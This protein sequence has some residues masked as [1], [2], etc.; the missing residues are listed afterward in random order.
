MGVLQPRR[1]SGAAVLPTTS[2]GGRPCGSSPRG[3]LPAARE[4]YGENSAM[5]DSSVLTKTPER[6]ASREN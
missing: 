1:L 2:D 5:L 6:L 4:T 3:K